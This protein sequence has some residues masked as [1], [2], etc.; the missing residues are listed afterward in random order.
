M[1]TII[2]TNP[3]F[4]DYFPHI[5]VM[6]MKSEFNL[7][8]YEQGLIRN[9]I[10]A[11]IKTVYS[12]LIEMHDLKHVNVYD[13]I[14]E[15]FDEKFFG[16]LKEGVH[17]HLH[18]TNAW[19]FLDKLMPKMEIEDE[20]ENLNFQTKMT[21]ILGIG[22]PRSLSNNRI[23][24]KEALIALLNFDLDPLSGQELLHLMKTK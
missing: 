5:P 9:E 4:Y 2:N 7:G 1:P 23:N 8:C 19:E 21:A 15:E 12:S 20:V 3:L 17:R 6:R 11:V 10:Q 16:E 22:L 18:G 14:G 24:L 13:E